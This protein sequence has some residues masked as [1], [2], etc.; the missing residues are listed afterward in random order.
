MLPQLE[1]RCS[2][3]PHSDERRDVSVGLCSAYGSAV[4]LR[5]H[6]TAVDTRSVINWRLLTMV[7]LPKHRHKVLDSWQRAAY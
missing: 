6:L 2:L 7:I 4:L 1:G 5:S 3:E